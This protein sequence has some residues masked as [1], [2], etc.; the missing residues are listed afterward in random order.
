MAGG[1]STISVV[2]PTII[3]VRVGLVVV[4]AVIPRMT[5]IVR[6]GSN[7]YSDDGTGKEDSLCFACHRSANG[8]RADNE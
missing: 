7:S 8:D 2:G 6:T 1:V 5:L 3:L 4:I